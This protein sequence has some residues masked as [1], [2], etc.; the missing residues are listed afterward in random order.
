M[1]RVLINGDRAYLPVD[2]MNRCLSEMVRSLDTLVEKD[3]YVLVIP[4]DV[5]REFCDRIKDLR[6]IRIKKTILP[7]F[8]FW[9]LI[10]IDIPGL[11][12][13]RIVVNPA[14]RSSIFGGGINILH[15][16][17]PLRFYGER[18]RRY[19]RTIRR[20]FYTSDC[21]I[22]PSEF[23]RDDIREAKTRDY[24]IRVIHLGW[25]HYP[26][27]QEDEGIFNEY[28]SIE[29]GSYY[30][31]VSAVSPHKNLKFI[32][33]AARRNPNRMF[34]IAG[35][36]NRGYGFEY[37]DLKNLL[38]VGR[39]DDK[40]SKA[41][42]M[43]CRAFIYPSLYEGAGLPPLE[44]LSCGVSVLASDIEVI[45]EYCGDAVHYFDPYDYD[46]D[47]E[48]A[49]NTKVSDPEEALGLLSW[50]RAAQELKS[51]IESYGVRRRL[52]MTSLKE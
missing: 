47:L 36:M 22:V 4:S 45:H 26:D 48:A 6:N 11:L 44:A 35:A 5:D 9:T 24:K 46:L 19:L 7:H 3:K 15:D 49:L 8:R 32:Y 38:F 10:Y 34:I 23:T 2:G 13:G 43:N 21:L 29:R 20:L 17:I 50:D 41:L 1:K 27:I 52:S 37:S 18:C 51:I 14:N 30:Y 16:I 40:K 25:Q 31:T 42:M 28:S 39:I 33:E 12:P